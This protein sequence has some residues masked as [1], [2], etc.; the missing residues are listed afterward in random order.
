[1][2]KLIE[3]IRAYQ[4]DYRVPLMEPL[5][6]EQTYDTYRVGGD[7]GIVYNIKATLGTQ[8]IIKESALY[9]DKESVMANSKKHVAAKIADE[10][11]G[12]FRAP[13]LKLRIICGH[14]QEGIKIVNDMLDSMFKV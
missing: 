14:N 5:S 1:M 8:V 12:E 6:L 9:N 4:T 13:L 3:Q 11:F 2:S 10:V 7:E